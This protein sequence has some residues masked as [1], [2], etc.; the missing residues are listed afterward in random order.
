[1]PTM[2][3]PTGAPASPP[4]DSGDHGFTP[5]TMIGTRYR[6]VGLLGRGGMGAVY[7]ADDL[8]LGQTV[9]L[10]FLPPDV[11]R[12][13][14]RL[15]QFIGEVRLAREVAHPNVCR[16][17][18]IG[19]VPD[20]S[21]RVR[22]F[23]SMEY[24]DGE[25]LRSLLRRIGRLPEDKAIEIARQIAA[26]LAA[27]HDRH[28]I[29]RDLKPANVMLD[30]QG[31]VRL[32]DFGLATNVASG[33]G[34]P[35]LAGTPQYM[36]PEQLSGEPLSPQTD[37]YALGL[38]L[39]EIFTGERV[40]KATTID[41]L[42]EAHRARTPVSMASGS[43]PRLDPAVL[44][45]IEL[46][47]DPDPK[48]R[49]KSALAVSAMLPGGD[50]IA[51]A[52]A[53]G[54]TPSPKMVA[55][56]GAEG[57]LA[58][59]IAIPCLVALLVLG[60]LTI[61][62]NG[63]AL[64]GSGLSLPNSPDVLS[65]RAREILT[66]IGDTSTPTD[67]ARGFSY[68]LDF[69]AWLDEHD[70]S[71]TRLRRLAS[72]R[73]PF[74]RFWYRTSPDHMLPERF[75]GVST[76]VLVGDDPP[77]TT[78]GMT[79]MLLSP[80]GR[81]LYFRRA[82]PDR[83][84]PPAQAVTVNWP[85]LFESAGLDMATFRQVTPEWLGHSDADTR[86]AWLGPGATDEGGDLR[87]EAAAL[88]GKPVFFALVA[89]WTRPSEA[90]DAAMPPTIR[91]AIAAFVIM[92]VAVLGAGVA[93]AIRHVR[94]GRA[95]TRGAARLALA[96]G[97]ITLAGTLAGLH[98]VADV[99]M[100]NLLAMVIAWG[101]FMALVT[102]TFYV[103]AEPH[104]RRRWPQVLISGSRVV[105]GRWRDPLVGRDLLFGSLVSFAM[106]L[107]LA[108]EELAVVWRGGPPQPPFLNT[109]AL[110]STL[111][112]LGVH[113]NAFP[114]AA[115]TALMVLLL[116]VLMRILLRSERA[117]GIGVLAIIF[118]LEV[119]TATNDPLIQ[120]PLRFAADVLLV[121]AMT[122]LGFVALV[123]VFF[124]GKTLFLGNVAIPSPEFLIGA[125]VI[126]AIAAL[127]PGVFGWYT[128]MSRKTGGASWLDA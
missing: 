58:P 93:L 66:R 99:G 106:T 32:T 59:K 53:A 82:L 126:G 91:A 10:K 21:G 24:I 87:V 7:R 36:A 76:G 95:D 81:L 114:I 39:W 47:L 9:A 31:R 125:T 1:M 45:A 34:R 112:A 11:E 15:N 63:R 27:M 5:G 77:M 37:L 64:F 38:V 71:P 86:A 73:V 109:T 100:V 118:G 55:A 115:C 90:G 29:H 60:G 70:K 101:G 83:A 17:Y 123:M 75:F 67:V 28:I 88:H 62:L 128:S 98:Y 14:G 22:R 19:E 48:Q 104:I 52:L 46:C 94:L 51:A 97:T 103:A 6:V 20:A 69:G 96:V 50:P 74:V 43:T 120:L 79:L 121:F 41:A 92:L 18:D 107:L 13:P 40:H 56:S 110:N 105:E 119:L 124:A 108:I 26:G 85:V 54:E 25:D 68:D 65:A 2:T 122:R 44:R 8:Q 57:A 78:P 16:V 49:P 111:A 30:G 80:Q 33:D 84:P 61:W 89:P 12:D 113:L 42:R 3:S 4:G 23:L 117:A 116:L 72:L 35:E 127:G 102:W